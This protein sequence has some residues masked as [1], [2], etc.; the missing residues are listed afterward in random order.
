MSLRNVIA[1]LIRRRGRDQIP[2][3]LA[4]SRVWHSRQSHSTLDMHKRAT[5]TPLKQSQ[6]SHAPNQHAP[7][8]TARS[9][10][11][12]YYLASPSAAGDTSMTGVDTAPSPAGVVVD[13]VAAA[14]VDADVVVADDF[15]SR[16]PLPSPRT[17][18]RSR[19]VI[20][21]DPARTGVLSSTTP[22]LTLGRLLPTRL[23]ATLPTRELRLWRRPIS[24]AAANCA[25]HRGQYRALNPSTCSACCPQNAPPHPPQCRL[26]SSSPKRMWHTMQPGT[27]SGTCRTGPSG[28]DHW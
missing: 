23:P 9:T 27:V 17:T 14:V 10:T 8:N 20:T 3:H 25:R 4:T 12:H 24:V 21:P 11:L 16:L 18:L 15:A 2:L 5:R 22:S 26:G 6:H 19:G 28:R 13:V 1:R 7:N